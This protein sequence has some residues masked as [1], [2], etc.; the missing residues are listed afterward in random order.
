MPRTRSSSSRRLYARSSSR[1]QPAIRRSRRSRLRAMATLDDRSLHGLTDRT[2]DL[3]QTLIRNECVNDGTT[4][5][6]H[7][8]RNVD[9]LEQVVVGSECRR[10]ALR[11]GARPGV[12]GGAD[13]RHGPAGTQPLPDG[14]HRRRPGAPRRVASR[15]VRRRT[16]RRRGVGARRGRH[17]QPHGVDGGGV[18]AAGRRGGCGSVPTDRRPDL[19]RGRRRGVGQRPRR[20]LDGRPSSRC[21]SCRLRPH[22]ERRAALGVGRDARSSV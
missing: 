19:L 15:P 13:R 3:L 20:A 17:A 21:D 9:V 18:P 7:E 2:V 11:A 5:S 6:G 4:G 14:P 12:D 8:T 16:D 22:R 10:R 1:A